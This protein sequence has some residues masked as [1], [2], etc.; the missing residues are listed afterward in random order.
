MGV[1]YGEGER[2]M[3]GWKGKKQYGTGLVCVVRRRHL[4]F[5]SRVALLEILYIA[6]YSPSHFCFRGWVW[7]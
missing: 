4:L 1:E 6:R 7:K 3:R 5:V 2:G